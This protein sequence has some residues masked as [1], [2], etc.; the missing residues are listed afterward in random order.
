M[1]ISN[2]DIEKFI[3]KNWNDHKKNLQKQFKNKFVFFGWSDTKNRDRHLWYI[4]TIFL[5][6]IDCAIFWK[7]YKNDK[8]LTQSTLRILLN[9]IFELDCN[10]NEGKMVT[11]IRKNDIKFG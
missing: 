4:S 6:E 10:A 1:A 7:F 11:F 2:V 9:E 5:Q 8:K 3:A